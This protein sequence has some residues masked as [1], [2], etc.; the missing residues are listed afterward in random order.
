[1]E[2]PWP[3]WG[4]YIT[5]L[6]SPLFSFKYAPYF[7]LFRLSQNTGKHGTE[8]LGIGTVFTQCVFL[9]ILTTLSILKQA[10]SFR[11]CTIIFLFFRPAMPIYM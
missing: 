4:Y 1:M 10:N 11:K 8:K 2:S 5:D 9:G 3:R 7:F 6:V